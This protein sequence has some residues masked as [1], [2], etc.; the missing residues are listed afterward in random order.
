MG[1]KKGEGYEWKNWGELWFG[2]R[3][4]VNGGEK[5]VGLWMGKVGVLWVGK[6]GGLRVGKM[7]KVK[8]GKRGMVIGRKIRGRKR[9]MVKGGKKWEGY[10]WEKWGW[11]WGE[12]GEG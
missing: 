2:K 9:G 1:G 12:K 3:G 6:G 10:E 8:G 5:G 4:R 7:G 11:L